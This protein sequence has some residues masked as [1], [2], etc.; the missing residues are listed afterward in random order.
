MD[1]RAIVGTSPLQLQVPPQG[2]NDVPTSAPP[3]LPDSKTAV[4]MAS[5]DLGSMLAAMLIEAGTHSREVARRSKEAALDAEDAAC[6]GKIES[7]KAEASHRFYAGLADGAGMAFEGVAAM[8]PAVLTKV[9]PDVLK[10]AG[11]MGKGIAKGGSAFWGES[12]DGAGR[13]VAAAERAITQARRNVEAASDSEK[14]AK[15]LL[16]RTL[17]HYKDFI[18]AKEDAQ[19]AATL[20][21]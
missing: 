10:G 3:V 1:C 15:D 13:E 9:S 20:R 5:G 21:A 4:L 12:A 19:K 16:R 18:T 6:V 17:D 11:G 2:T 8:S 7:M 14:D